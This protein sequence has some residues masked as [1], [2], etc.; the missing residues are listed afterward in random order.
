MERKDFTLISES[1]NLTLHG[2]VYEPNGEIKGIFQILHGMGEYRQRYDE[3]MRF[4][5]ENGFIAACHDHRGHGDSVRADGDLGYFYETKSKAIVEDSAQVTK[6]LQAQY[7]NLPVVLFGH[8]MGSM[9]AR[10]YLQKYD[11]LVCGAI[12]CGSPAKNSFTGV[13]I[14]LTKCIALFK[15]DHHRSKMLAYLSTGKGNDNFPDE[16]KG[17][18]LSR[19]RKNIDEFYSHPKGKFGFTCNGFENL[20]RLMKNT[21]TPKAYRVQNPKLPIF[22]VSGGDDAVL[23]SEKQWLAA[24][25]MLKKAGYTNV[26][27]KLYKGLRHEIH[28]ELENA[29][30]LADLLGFALKSVNAQK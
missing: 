14:A 10:C 2:T 17:A 13:A 27:G 25:E 22:F 24:M 18:W 11:T 1:D 20:F 7:P 6:Y 26:T 21:Y 15:G 4:F 28:N 3:L 23:G 9:I 29:E 12:I 8:S 16:P 30:P 5:A 19:N